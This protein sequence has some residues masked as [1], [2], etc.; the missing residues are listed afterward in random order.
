[1]GTALSTKEALLAWVNTQ[2]PDQKVKNFTTDWNNGIALCALVDRIKPGLCP[3]YA[4]LKSSDE[5]ENCTLGMDLAED[6]LG[7]LKLLEPEDLCHQEVDELSVMTYISSFCKPAND[8]LLEWIQS[9]IP[10]QNITNFNKDWNNGINLSCLLD[11]LIPGTI[12]D[13]RQLDPHQ[14]LDNLVQALKVGEEHL[15]VKPVL[16][17]SQLADPKVD[18]LNVATYLSRFQ[19]ARPIPQPHLVTCKG[20]GLFKAVV[21]Q[22]ATFEVDGSKGGVG[23]LTVV[24]SDSKNNQI[25][26]EL[27]QNEGGLTEVKY[28]P[29]VAGNLTIEVKWSDS[30]IPGSPFNPDAIDLA[31]FSFTGRQITGGQSTKIGSLVV[32][33]AKGITEVS[34]LYVLIQHSDGHTE[35]AKTVLLDSGVIECTYSPT[36]LGKDEVFAKVAGTEI[37][38]SPFEV[39]VVDPSQ[40]SVQME[41]PPAGQPLKANRPAKFTVMASKANLGGIIAEVT[42]PGSSKAEELNIVPQGDESNVATFTPTD[43]GE[44]KVSVTCAEED[45]RG[46]PLELVAIDPAKCQFLDA[47]PSFVQVGKSCNVRLSVKGAGEGSLD[48]SSSQTSVVAVS[49]SKSIE[50]DI[51]TIQ[52][53][54]NSVGEVTMD[55]K[56]EGTS[57]APTPC[58]VKVCDATKCSAYG[59]GLTEGRGKSAKPFHFTVQTKGAGKGELVVKPHGKKATY[60]AEIVESSKGTYSVNF[61]T[62]EVGVHTID[63]LWGDAHIPNSPFKVDFVKVGD[64]AQFT[65]TGDG[66]KEAT[67]QST[68]K[69]LLVGPTSGLLADNILQVKVSGD[70]FESKVVSKDKFDPKCGSAVVCISDNDNGSYSV[71]YAVPTPGTCSLSI[72]SDGE[73]IPG[74]PFNVKVLPPSDASKCRAFGKHIDNP[75][76]SVVDK[77]LE[78]KVDTTNAGSGNIVATATGPASSSVPVFTAEDKSSKSGKV[79]ALKIDP[80]HKGKH[81]VSVLWSG[82]HIPGSPFTFDVGDPKDVVVLNLPDSSTYVARVNEPISF[83]VDAS[84]AGKGDLKCV[85]KLDGGK[86]EPFTFKPTENG[87]VSLTYTPRHAGHME[88]VLTYSGENVFTTPWQCDITNPSSFQVIPPKDH[89]RQ[90][91]YAKFIVSGLSERNRNKIKISATHPEHLKPTIKDETVHGSTAVYRFTAKKLGEYEVNVKVGSKHIAG[92]PFWVQVANPDGCKVK[93]DIPTVLPIGATKKLQVN[94]ASCG[95][96]ELTF[97]VDGADSSTYLDCK[98]V[99]DPSN[100]DVQTVKMTGLKCGKC[101]F[102]LQWGGF[103]IPK[104]P[105]NIVVVD[106]SKCSLDCEQVKSKLVKTSDKLSFTVNTYNGGNLPPEVVATG[107]KA[108]YS[109]EVKKISEGEYTAS[110]TPWQDGSQTVQVSMGGVQLQGA[111]V[112]FEAV[113]PLDVGKLK[114][115][116]DGLRQAV[117]NR[118][119]K[120]TIL[121]GEAKL[122]NKG[123]L[124]VAFKSSTR[125]E[126]VEMDISDEQNGSY[127]VSYKPKNPGKLKM[128]VAVEG[129]D[130]NGSPFDIEVLPEPDASM[131]RITDASG[132]KVHFLEGSALYHR[133]NTP[134]V[135]SVDV[136]KAGTGTLKASGRD[137]NGKVVRVLAAEEYD[138][139]SKK[140]LYTLRFDPAVIGTYALN[141]SWDSKTLPNAPYQIR[142][143][144]PKKCSLDVPFPMFLQ[145]DQMATI[146]V[147]TAEA[148]EANLDV[149]TDGASVEAKVDKKDKENFTVTLKGIQLGKTLVQ[150]KYGGF[151]YSEQPHAVSVCDPKQCGFAD[152]GKLDVQVGVPFTITVKTEN[153]GKAD[154]QVKP[155]DSEMQYTFDVREESPDEWKATCTAWNLGEHEL[156]VLWGEWELPGSPIKFNA[157]DPKRIKVSDIP[158]PQSYVAVIGEPISFSV[159]YSEAGQGSL[160]CSVIHGDGEEESVARDETNEQPDVAHLSVVPKVPGKME[161][162]LKY[163]GVELISPNLTYEVPDPSM[164]QVIPP[165]GYGKINDVIKFAVT[166]VT[167]DTELTFKATHLDQEAV[168]T[169]EKGKDESNII[170]QFRAENVGEYEVEVKLKDQHVAGSPFTVKVANPEGCSIVGVLPSVVHSGGQGVFE[171]D[172]SSAGPGDLGLLTEV[173]SGE[174]EPALSQTDDG[175]WSISS[176]GGVG[177]CK[178]TAKWADYIVKD[179]PF[180]IQFVE[181]GNVT[182]S[183]DGIINGTVK[184]GEEVGIHLD[185]SRAGQTVP[186]VKAVGPKS[187]FAVQTTNNNDGTFMLTLNPYQVGENAVTVL[188][189]GKDIPGSPF[190]FNVSK[191]IEART[192]IA[193]GEGTK[194]AMTNDPTTVSINAPDSGLLDGTD[195]PL[196]A[197]LIPVGSEEDLVNAA[198]ADVG[199]GSYKLTYT[200][201]KEGDYELEIL[202]EKQHIYGSPFKVHAFP[203]P[204][205]DKCTIFGKDLQDNRHAFKVNSGIQFGVDITDAGK[206]ELTITGKDPSGKQIT[207]IFTNEQERRGKRVKLARYTPETV[208]H[209]I[210]E[211][212]WEGIDIPDSPLDFSIVDPSKCI[213]KD[214][215]PQNGVVQNEDIKPI[216]FSILCDEAGDVPPEVSVSASGVSDPMQLQPSSKSASIFNYEFTPGSFGNVAIS[217]L[218]GGF[219]VPNSPFKFAVVDPNRYSVSGLNLPG[220][221]ARIADL[222]VFDISSKK[223]GSDDVLDITMHGPKG[224]KDQKSVIPQKGKYKHSFTPMSA[225]SYD[226]FVECL[227]V[228]VSGSPLQ[229]NV[230]DPHKCQIFGRFPSHFQVKEEEEVV[231]NTQ[232]AGEGEIQVLFSGEKEHHSVGCRIVR[233]DINSYSLLFKGKQIDSTSVSIL[234]G[235]F[236]IKGSPFHI[237]I[238]DASKCKVHG[239]VLTSLTA[240]TGEKLSFSVDTKEAGKSELSVVPKGPSATYKPDIKLVDRK[241]NV[242]FTPWEVGQLSMDVFWGNSHIPNSPFLINVENSRNICNATGDGLKTAVVGQESS[243]TIITSEMGLLGKKA[244]DV[245]IAGVRSGRLKGTVTDNVNGT[246]TVS[247]TPQKPGAYVANITVNKNLVLGSPFK[248]NVVSAP[249]A[250]KCIAGGP[251]LQPKAV[252]LTGSHL[253]VTV[254]SSEAGTGKL[255]AIIHGPNEYS[256]KVYMSEGVNGLYSIKF[257]A[258]FPGRYS[259]QLLWSGQEIPGSPFNVRVHPAPDA[260]KVRAY[261]SGLEDGYVNTPGNLQKAVVIVSH[262]V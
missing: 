58:S 209:H 188:W 6:E 37:P 95:S 162:V 4:T 89:I 165:K 124:A 116:G 56:W 221:Y 259:V 109:V 27:I 94:T 193:S 159:D 48:V 226:I 176:S 166:G 199:G 255:E 8:R 212:K 160:E 118:F 177:Q 135:L 80:K 239:T 215:P 241:Y 77:S 87:K 76:D 179:T 233:Q 75:N 97:K 79:Y 202:F 191:A 126:K 32:M 114:I 86:L 204:K 5:L 121:A 54:P 21:G 50:P 35:T 43:I 81:R 67:A 151:S 178:V 69:C 136:S 172:T 260:S 23:E 248:I 210:L 9:V 138:E 98:V 38:G 40:C 68:A 174:I 170:A 120:V 36:R 91:D 112:K 236:N 74:S 235:G 122:L 149:V 16:T 218:F 171:V 71:Q 59:P 194:A 214:L 231:L 146:N 152:L 182:S 140:R 227:G 261:G 254:D 49:S 44:Y 158:D 110:F 180:V 52:V 125:E 207:T 115:T 192:I 93:G 234:W 123:R 249:D 143:V 133:I 163:N 28:V 243:F 101:S 189:G 113:K 25:E 107:P 203:S 29:H 100:P 20:H 53:T 142:V 141:L 31:A 240:T 154:L 3:Q 92:S 201:I 206:G 238:S 17:P 229:I 134:V 139:M 181:S 169:A 47:V 157:V 155:V 257:Q 132:D 13:C 108:R 88:I 51:Y 42:R 14:S 242:S 26:V 45:I 117:A 34:D 2:I 144:D 96:G 211:L 190:K 258:T 167:A 84:K 78:F 173:I 251:A 62:Y 105:V 148:G 175:K 61:T 106:P 46:S 217:V 198:L 223:Y 195:P 256:P 150:M 128:R 183:C 85:A 219:S 33:E 131:C 247:Y 216:H 119:N 168:V 111:P 41:D 253:E 200:A 224:E 10:D 99:L 19:Y 15:G 83:A 245:S 246:Y 187:N 104:M 156:K 185:A 230:V 137:P 73:H 252:L 103:D 11:A 102:R 60:A 164:F 186:V 30:P 232:G 225:G 127:I 153:A 18:D 208:G 228:Q 197:S 145:P 237:N 57:I 22:A 250:S 39:K 184:Q 161:L 130:I 64:A 129:K 1:M 24:A 213:V 12:P 196:T 63:V 7:I 205:A 72:T 66:L 70:K 220:K 222:V 147:C 65:V 90:N 82:V 244:I 55:V 262:I